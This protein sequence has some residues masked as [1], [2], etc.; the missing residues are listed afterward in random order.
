MKKGLVILLMVLSLSFL[1]NIYTDKKIYD[2]FSKIKVDELENIDH[3]SNHNF[4][5]Y[6]IENIG[7]NLQTELLRIDIESSDIKVRNDM[8]FFFQ[9]KVVYISNKER[10]IK[11]YL[12]YDFLKSKFRIT[13][14]QTFNRERT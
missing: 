7:Y 10:C 1:L 6:G 4:Y 11:V 8:L 3:T 2:I 12:K 5:K 13:G 14:Y 9:Q